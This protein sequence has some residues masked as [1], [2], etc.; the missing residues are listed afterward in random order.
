M[1]D[2]GFEGPDPTEIVDD[3]IREHGATTSEES[4]RQL[5]LEVMGPEEVSQLEII[6]LAGDSSTTFN[7]ELHGPTRL[8]KKAFALLRKK[9]NRS[10]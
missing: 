7:V 3:I 9:R 2:Y 5:L 4:A 10:E 6:A 8:V 1:I